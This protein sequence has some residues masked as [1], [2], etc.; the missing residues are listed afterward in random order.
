MS[1]EKNFYK[2]LSYS[3]PKKCKKLCK[4]I[5]IELIKKRG[6]LGE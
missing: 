2:I 3:S 5:A 6:I 1:K 4:K